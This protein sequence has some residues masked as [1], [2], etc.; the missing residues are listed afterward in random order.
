MTETSPFVVVASTSDHGCDASPRG[1][2]AGDRPKPECIIREHI[3][4]EGD[5]ADVRQVLEA[6]YAKT[7]WEVGGRE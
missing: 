4:W 7:M 1:G 3:A 6:G 2:P 5:G